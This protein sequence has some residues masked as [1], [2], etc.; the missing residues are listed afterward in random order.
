MDSDWMLNIRSSLPEETV[1]LG[2][3]RSLGCYTC[4]SGKK[5]LVLLHGL[6]SYSGTW[7]K[8]VDALSSIGRVFAPT[9]PKVNF[10]A[11]IMLHDAVLELSDVVV[12]LMDRMKAGP[13]IIIGN[14]MG[15]WIGLYLAIHRAEL[16]ESLVLVD[17]A[18]I[19]PPAMRLPGHPAEVSEHLD[20]ISK[21]VLI[22]WG[23]DD[24]I[25]PLSSATYLHN[26]IR[27]STLHIIRGAG[28]IPHLERPLVFNSAVLAFLDGKEGAAVAGADS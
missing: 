3:G 17:S 18:G 8:N 12:E 4:G 20:S 11:G 26:H 21:P 6:N 28:H 16:V 24:S 25:I 27:H 19:V 1:V 13:S 14:S 15:G 2:S 7:K 9:L 22:V 5:S 23:E 10:E